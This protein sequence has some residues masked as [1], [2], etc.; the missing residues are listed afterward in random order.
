MMAAEDKELLRAVVC[1]LVDH[2]TDV[3]V[4]EELKGE[5]SHMLVRVAPEDRGRVIGK[6]GETI[7]SLR[8]LFGRI[9]AA[10]G[11]KTFIQ[12]EAC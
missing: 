8:V 6:G 3:A 5:D 2:P 7:G 11:R 1:R 10:N 9:A 12:V 4:D